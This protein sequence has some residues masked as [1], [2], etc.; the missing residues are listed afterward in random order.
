MLVS[1][2]NVSHK[3][4]SC[5]NASAQ[6][7]LIKW[8]LI[9]TSVETTHAAKSNSIPEGE[10]HSS[11]TNRRQSDKVPGILLYNFSTRPLKMGGIFSP[12]I[13]SINETNHVWGRRWVAAHTHCLAMSR[14]VIDEQCRQHSSTQHWHPTCNYVP[15]IGKIGIY[16]GQLFRAWRT[17]PAPRGTVWPELTK[18]DKSEHASNLAS[19]GWRIS[20]QVNGCIILLFFSI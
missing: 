5:L 19:K 15:K 1:D 17:V 4:F 6:N 8:F 16:I 13:N 18:L 2:C 3:S 10:P 20:K 12:H 11:Q 9:C 14:A 7:P